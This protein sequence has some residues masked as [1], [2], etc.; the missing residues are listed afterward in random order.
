[1]Q[2]FR[3]LKIW[4]KSHQVVLALYKITA[5][6]PKDE[7]YSLTSQI[8]RAAVSIPANIAEGCVRG[9]DPEFGRF[10]YIAQG[11]ASELDYHLYLSRDLGYISAPDYRSIS[12]QLAEVR[13]MLNNFIRTLKPKPKAKS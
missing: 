3:N 10:L 5:K 12:Q 13:R 11:S 9:S 7:I 2:D 6:F 4:Q 1:M 8:R